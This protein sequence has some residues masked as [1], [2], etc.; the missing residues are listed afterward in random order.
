[1]LTTV[2][3]SLAGKLT[4]AFEGSA[5]I[6]GAA[7]QFLRDQVRI[8]RSASDTEAMASTAT[9]APEVYFVPALAGLGAPYW[10]P[11]AQGAFFGLTRGTSQA[12]M[13]RAVLEGI[14]FQVR[15][16]TEAIARD[17]GSPLQVLRVDGGASA[18]SLLMQVQA[19]YSA[20]RVDR[21]VNLETTA[22]GAALFAGLGIG[23]YANLEQLRRVRRTEHIFS[24]STSAAEKASIARQIAGW[25]RAVKAVQVFAGTATA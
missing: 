13:V 17:L 4:Y 9:A 20:I 10:D 7:V 22:F 14:A 15:E 6:A 23:L 21:P 1:M 2:A 19:D 8:I 16:L 12:Q 5:F 18:N 25:Q 24:P 11:K 3:W